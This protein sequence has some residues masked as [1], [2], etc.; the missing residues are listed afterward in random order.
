MA[1]NL[2]YDVTHEKPEAKNQKFCLVFRGLN[3]CLAQSAAGVMQ[4]VLG[5]FPSTIYSQT[6]SQSINKLY[7]TKKD[8][9]ILLATVPYTFTTKYKCTK[10][11]LD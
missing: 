2:P 3:S 9:F 6:S 10:S 5:R 1:K 8:L 11:Y 4:M 7:N